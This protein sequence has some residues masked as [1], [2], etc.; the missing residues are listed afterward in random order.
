MAEGRLAGSWGALGPVAVLSHPP[1]GQLTC[2]VRAADIA[3]DPKGVVIGSRRQVRCARTHTQT[4]T[5]MLALQPH[6]KHWGLRTAH[7]LA[8]GQKPGLCL[9]PPWCLGEGDRSTDPG[10]WASGEGQ[11]VAPPGSWDTDAIQRWAPGWGA[12]CCLG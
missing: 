7:C 11:P 2:R 12:V 9:Q 4:H 10:L 6:P 5:H 3:L 1:D 8:P